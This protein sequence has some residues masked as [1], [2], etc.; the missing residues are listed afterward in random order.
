VEVK[1]PLAVTTRVRKRADEPATQLFNRFYEDNP[2]NTEEQVGLIERPALTTL[3]N[4]GDNNPGRRIFRQKGF[5]S[6]D[7]FHVAGLN[8]YR[9]NLNQF[10]VI[11]TTQ[12]SGIVQGTGAPDMCATNGYLFIAD[13]FTLQYTN[14]TAALA[15]VDI[16]LLTPGIAFASVDVF[17][18]YVL[19]SVATSDRFYWLQPGSLQFQALDFATAEHFPDKILQIRVVGDEFW[20]LGE[21]SVEVWRATGQGS[22]PFERVEGRAFN[23]GIYGGTAVR[24][25]DTSVVLVADDGTVFD[26]RGTPKEISNPAIAE[27]TRNAILAALGG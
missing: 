4:V 11:T 19:A 8:L 16:S 21:K 12:I 26:I 13:G 10:R 9:H 22:A 15:G 24:M 14:G 3:I 23:F 2:T 27:K 6:G 20:L 7:L 5:A 18:G 25:K 17:N 1:V